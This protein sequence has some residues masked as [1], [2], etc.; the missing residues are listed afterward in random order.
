MEIQ[1]FWEGFEARQLQ[2]SARDARSFVRAWAHGARAG[3]RA[4]GSE[5]RRAVPPEAVAMQSI[6]MSAKRCLQYNSLSTRAN[7]RHLLRQ[8]AE[9]PCC[10]A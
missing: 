10:R 6:V 5:A 2:R 9:T 1:Q 8:K 7:V 3:L 4:S